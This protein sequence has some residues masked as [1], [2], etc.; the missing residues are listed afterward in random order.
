VKALAEQLG[1]S[2]IILGGHDWYFF[3]ALLLF[4]P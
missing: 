3:F 4:I 2:K 1:A